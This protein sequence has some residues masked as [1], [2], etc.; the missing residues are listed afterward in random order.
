MTSASNLR[1]DN[2][3]ITRADVHKTKGIAGIFTNCS[4]PLLIKGK[5]IP[6]IATTTSLVT[7]LVCLE[8]YKVTAA[9][10]SSPFLARWWKQ[11]DW[12]LEKRICQPCAAILRVFW[13]DPSTAV[14][15]FSTPL[16]LST[17]ISLSITMSSFPCGIDSILILISRCNNCWIISR[18]KKNWRSRCFHAV[19]PCS[20]LFSC[21]RRN[22]KN[23]CHSSN[24]KNH[25]LT[26][27]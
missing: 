16:S 10:C 18:R 15:G 4:C 1:A 21:R 20:T 2:Y 5:I 8:Y 9:L 13:A 22:W 14:E 26:F 7:G 11:K 27:R 6:A 12:R 23:A 3:A 24:G 17:E 19:S 25:S